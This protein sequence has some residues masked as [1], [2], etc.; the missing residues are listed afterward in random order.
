M[1]YYS[2]YI[3]ESGSEEETKN[4]VSVVLQQIKGGKRH[5]LFAC[6]CEGEGNGEETSYISGY[7]TARLVEWF[8]GLFSEKHCGAE[9]GEQM[10]KRLSREIVLI[11]E[12]LW[13]NSEEKGLSESYHILGILLCEQDFLCFAKGDYKGYLFNRRFNRKQRV[14]VKKRFFEGNDQVA[15]DGKVGNVQYVFGHLQKNV[16]IILCNK[17]FDIYF[18][19]H[20]LIEVLG[21]DGLEEEQ[22]NRRLQELWKENQHRGGAAYAGAVYFRIG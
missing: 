7:V 1:K 5:Y 20:E 3:W 19:E 10:K 12:E 11:E 6:I 15:R 22:I 8:H 17:D 9:V 21:E 14:D 4:P 2:H 18:S 13:A 16:G